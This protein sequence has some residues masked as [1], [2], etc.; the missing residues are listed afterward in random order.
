MPI[1]TPQSTPVTGTPQSLSTETTPVKFD[2]RSVTVAP[3]GDQFI[4]SQ[5]QASGEAMPLP[6]PIATIHVRPP[7]EQEAGQHF[8]TNPSLIDAGA[9]RTTLTDEHSI[10]ERSNELASFSTSVKRLR[11]YIDINYQD[12]MISDQQQA[13][14][15][16]LTDYNE[17]FDKQ[18]LRL[19]DLAS[20]IDKNKASSKQI[21]EFNALLKSH[22]HNLSVVQA[23]LS[24]MKAQSLTPEGRALVNAFEMRFAE[25]H[26]DLADIMTLYSDSLPEQEPISREERI[27]YSL[28][29]ARGCLKA[30][31]NM[32]VPG[33]NESKRGR[34]EEAM[35]QHCAKL[36]QF[37]KFAK[38]EHDPTRDTLSL[39]LLTE[40]FTL[41]KDKKKLSS[42]VLSPLYKQWDQFSERANM[43]QNRAPIPLT[44]AKISQPKMMELFVNHQLKAAGVAEQDMPNL[45]FLFKQGM[46][47]ELNHKEWPEVNKE[48]TFEVG[49]EE[50]SAQSTI[51]PAAHMAK[52]FET[53]YPSNGISSIDRMQYKHVPN[54]AHS[55]M[56]GAN[57]E[58]LFSGIRH[59]ALDPYA[60]NNKNLRNLPTDQVSQMIKELLLETGAVETPE[61]QHPDQYANTLAQQVKAGNPEIPDIAV[62][63]RN[64]SSKMMAQE[65]LA[66]AVVSDPG[67]LQAALAGET[68]PV[69][70][71]SISLVTPDQIRGRL[72]TGSAGDEKTMLARQTQSLKG[73]AATGE[74]VKIKVRDEQGD[75]R[76]I[77]VMPKVRTFNFG[78]NRGAVARSM[79]VLGPSTPL[80]GR[81]MGWE[82]AAS[83]NN[84]ELRDLLGNPRSR[85]LGGA[86]A[87]KLAE[88]STSG[89]MNIRKQATLLRQSATQAKMIWNSESFRRG[90]RE[91]YKMV[92]RLALISHLMGE[93]TLYNCKSGKDRTGQLDAEV[94]YLASVGNVT[95]QI[96]RPETAHTDESRRMRSNFALN[97]GNHEVQ[98]MTAGLRGYKLKGVPGLK[99]MMESD[100]MDIYHGGSKFVKT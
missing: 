51:T 13:T 70:L 49:G 30:L 91:P 11:N 20:K 22:K 62:K 67:K 17:V 7:D 42:S 63:L 24:G 6:R 86:V 45:Q 27:G 61:G 37:E 78:V 2:N 66:T 1:V 23:H 77:S 16:T 57:G 38:G 81:A 34:I 10:A 32:A 73:L 35:Q 31:E 92:S 55:Q 94:K 64:E 89:D 82:F 100:M 43:S 79:G 8:L 14:F 36:E 41:V 3:P 76:T 95:G 96:P 58:V 65:L 33:L 46:V 84:P 72:K 75:I 56:V 60:I 68:V 69:S 83:M 40:D 87:V 9:G 85:E 29:Q 48:L 99:K 93:T 26:L 71:N 59:G 80:W 47:D 19:T 28:L 18:M 98:Q 25:R 90:G 52:H 54:M 88:M 4:D 97:T 50:H 74:P 15:A 5:Q 21:H 44:H 39:D 12:N 53:D